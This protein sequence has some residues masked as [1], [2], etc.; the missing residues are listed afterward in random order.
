ME[1]PGD[2]YDFAVSGS[3][4]M[5][6]KLG[7]PKD[8]Y[9]IQMRGSSTVL[10]AIQKIGSRY[11]DENSSIRLPLIGGGT[12]I[13]YKSVLDGT[14]SIGMASGH[15]PPDISL[16][17]DKNKLT[18]E[19]I[20]IAIDGIAAIVNTSNPL[21]DLSLE[22]LHGVFT[23]KITNWSALGNFS[24]GINVI[25]HDPQLGTYEHWK[26]QVAGSEHITLKAKVVSN[27]T[28]LFQ[29]IATDRLAI[30]YVG[31]TF[32]N[33]AKV[34]PIAINGV[35]PTYQNI[36]EGLYPIQNELQLL[37]RPSASQEIKEFIAYCLSDE[38][39]QTIIKEMGLV[40]IRVKS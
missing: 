31:V 13:G 32:L 30:G 10:K 19:S 1:Y 40:P 6:I 38:K 2:L 25:S 29:L 21:N 9:F 34:K 39:G 36:Y 23:G 5:S 27:I 18:L 26:R 7:N 3:A 15:M 33:K 20:P 14:S 8:I 28:D 12:S 24:G 35:M 37:T 16:W 22:Q 11:M 17:A 4:A